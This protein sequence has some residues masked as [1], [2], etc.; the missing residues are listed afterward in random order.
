MNKRISLSSILVALCLCLGTPAFAQ[1][2][3]RNRTVQTV[4]SD[5]LAQLPAKSV[6]KYDEVVAEMAATGQ[7]GVEILAD[8]LKP[9]ATNQNATV[10]YA[11]DAIASYATKTDNADVKK[12]VHDG[13][14]AGMSRC[15]DEANRAFLL[16]QLNKL[17]LPSDVDAYIALLPDSYLR[18]TAVAGLAKMPGVDAK[19]AEYIV[20]SQPDAD[21]AYLAYCRNLK[22]VEP[23]L[24]DWAASGN[25]EVKT[26]AYNA[27][28]DLGSEKSYKTLYDAAK[29]Q[30]FANDPT[31]ATDAYLRL[32]GRLGNS[33]N[34]IAGAN[35]LMK[36][37]N[38]A[39]RCAGLR[40]LLHADKANAQKNIQAALK[41]G[42][43][44]YRNTALIEAEDVAGN[45]IYNAV[46]ANLKSMS[47]GAQADVV[48]WLGNHHIK[49]QEA[50][51]SGLVASKNQDVA[52]AATEAAS[53]IGGPLAM[54][55]LIG[56]LG[57]DSVRAA[58]A[59]KALVSYKGDIASGVLQAL[60]SGNPGTQKEAAKLA[61]ARRIYSAYAPMVA[62]AS[63]SDS[64]VAK[65]ALENL[66]GV[67]KPEN[68]D[69]ICDLLAAATSPE[70]ISS[71]Q[72]A[73]KSSISTLDSG[74]QYSEASRR[75]K[76]APAGKASRYYPILAQ[77]GNADAIN[78]LLSEY[79]K[80]NSD[81]A[82]QALLLVDNPEMIDVL[83]GIA[84]KNPSLKD[85]A[86]NRYVRL[87]K[88]AKLPALENYRLA[89]RAL[90]LNPSYDMQRTLV[91]SLGNSPTVPALMLATRYLDN[92]S[93]SYDAAD[94]VK[95]IVSKNEALRQGDA[96][97]KSLEKT[98]DVFLAYKVKD[99]DAGYAADQVSG[100][101]ADFVPEGGFYTVADG[102]GNALAPLTG[103]QENFEM[104]F[105]WDSTQPLE[106]VLRGA[107]L[108]KADAQSGISVAGGKAV[109]PADGW[110]TI[111]V[112]M[113]NDRLF[114]DANGETLA[115]NEVMPLMADGSKVAPRGPVSINGGKTA[116]VRNV[117]FDRLADTPV[118]VLPAD[119]AA[120]GFEV[121]FDGRDLDKW[122][123]NTSAYVPVDG[124]I[125]VT[126]QYGGT[127]NLYTKD[128][129]SDFILRFEFF[130]DA[131]A[132]NNGIGIRTGKGVTGVDAAY[133]G[134]EIQVLDHDDPVYQG[135][136]FGYKGLRPYQNHGS[137]YGV[138][139][140]K[141][142]DFGPIRQ[143]HT[144]EIKAVGDRIIVTVDGEVINDVD[145]REAC[146]GHN[147]APDGS[148]R[149]PYTVDHNNHPGLFNKEGYISFC[150]HGPGVKFRNVRVL[151][152][153]K[154]AKKKGKKK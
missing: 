94:A 133:D 144:E 56:A 65:T 72:N 35:E 40:L 69:Q 29:A 83:Y 100:F 136:P 39:V 25:K 96:A 153:T 2:D 142:V 44:Q 3:A 48:R 77:A 89:S 27:L 17:V 31:G 74:K 149:N 130:F 43:I 137:V 113:L 81:E 118:F 6:K 146:Q 128:T 105:D 9:A 150:G 24:I 37:K 110:N 79:N 111:R 107:P 47:P 116:G 13:L 10:E 70:A 92:D 132:V 126:A 4:I 85:K 123:G 73:A 46:A 21:L 15:K 63:G 152:L 139:P 112:K 103:D 19:V 20:A 125:Y 51:V 127:G 57:S 1:V 71:L 154:N 26:A 143:W 84:Q 42:D 104:Y 55:A 22:E 66:S 115:V 30:N 102:T 148:D 60:A 50:A 45:G 95:T 58:A 18:Q 119:E 80:G 8:M 99:A 14:M 52:L 147:V 117:Y 114:V 41:D 93:T 131:P 109:A 38:Q 75:L 33:K 61:S 68:F 124:N 76:S 97:K 86:L 78:L 34:A 141:H 108:V 138:A 59:S 120:Q 36:N 5:G 90:D 62:L 16:T 91:S 67:V 135:H 64:D 87:A 88:S 23:T 106:L 7:P 98:R 11:I 121:L 151:D 49:A 53:K 129:Y 122:H 140:S 101:L 28:G 145:I 32:V 82:F 134:M 12:G 54:Q